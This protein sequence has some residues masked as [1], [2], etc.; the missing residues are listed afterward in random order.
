MTLR[1][2]ITRALPY[3]LMAAA[4]VL[5]VVFFALY[6]AHNINA[7]DAS[8]MIL[9]QQLNGE[10]KFLSENWLYSTE[11]R[12]ISPVPL[13]Q[14][15]LKLFTSWHMARTF[16]M[17][18]VLLIVILSSLFMM[19]RL[20]LKKSA[21]W[22]ATVLALPF[23]GTYAYIVVFGCYY[24]L[25]L[26]IAFIMLG[27][28]C[29]FG[30]RGMES[31]KAQFAL[32]CLL[33]LVSGL[34]G[35]RMMTMFIAPL[36]AAAALLAAWE[37]KKEERFSAVAHEPP[38]RM[39]GACLGIVAFS[40]AGFLVN[41]VVL[42]KKYQYFTYADMIVGQFELSDVLH[43]ISGMIR[44]LGYRTG[45]AFF[46]LDGIAALVTLGLFVLMLFALVRLLMRWKDIGSEVRILA[47]TSVVAIVLGM[48]LNILLNQIITRYF[49]IGT[50]LLI[51]VMFAWLETEPCKNAML[52]TYALALVTF[53]FAFQAQN[54][55][56]YDY[57]I[58]RVNYE[59]T[60][61]W[62]LERGYTQGYATFWNANT[63]TEASNG[64]IEMW[65]LE[66]GRRNAWMNLVLHDILQSKDH[67]TRDPE[68][69]VFL[70]VDEEQNKV[71]SPL[72]NPEHLVGEM[73]AWSYYVYEYDSV[74]EMRA[75]IAGNE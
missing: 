65:V 48:A 25:H 46:A 64:Q 69:R 35:V 54:V 4:Y 33:A 2:K 7:D 66:D 13:Y 20:E 23:S 6:G 29:D 28:L 24:A 37:A 57:T 40:A 30:R 34:G 41:E 70:L 59:M 38:I 27:L 44:D 45:K 43:Q 47:V 3:A 14:M 60:A 71:D 11:L 9:A 42:P 16:A 26:S 50:I 63:L 58:G 12:I 32:L 17:G 22:F 19:R 39:F 55:L 67:Q 51:A 61:D 56:R 18:I 10:G 62:L 8:E 31:G 52:R 72:L 73:V 53:C 1:K 68:G 5:S 74:D 21:P 75:L 36:I 15:G 49:L